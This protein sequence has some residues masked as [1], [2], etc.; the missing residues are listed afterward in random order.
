MLPISRPKL[1]IK[2]LVP[3]RIGLA[4]LFQSDL[5]PRDEP[6]EMLYDALVM[7]LGLCGLSV[8]SELHET[9]AGGVR[10][11]L[12]VTWGAKGARW[13]ILSLGLPKTSVS[14]KT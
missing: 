10:Y 6:A 11:G 8:V 5:R 4:L 13:F 12:C 3:P 14:V 9:H 7:V 1:P 2:N